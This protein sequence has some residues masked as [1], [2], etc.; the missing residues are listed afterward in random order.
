MSRHIPKSRS[1][2]LRK[3]CSTKQKQTNKKT[4]RKKIGQLL[5]QHIFFNK[6]AGNFIEKEALAS[7]SIFLIGSRIFIW[8]W[9]FKYLFAKQKSMKSLCE[10]LFKLMDSIYSSNITYKCITHCIANVV[11]ANCSELIFEVIMKTWDLF[12]IPI[13]RRVREAVL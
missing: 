2:L 5:F 4:I 1:S 13:I 6:L 8:F 9:L 10:K 3:R 11:A 7:S 12:W